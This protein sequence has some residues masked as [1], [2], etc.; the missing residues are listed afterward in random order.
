LVVVDSQQRF[1]TE[2]GQ[3]YVLRR[4]CCGHN[5]GGGGDSSG[6]GGN[7]RDHH[8]VPLVLVPL[9]LRV[10]PVADQRAHL[11]ESLT[12]RFARERF[13]LHVHVPATDGSETLLINSTRTSRR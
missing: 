1:D 8:L 11:T 4:V 12:A 2:I 6:G 7:L 10:L 9:A 5:D 3:V 13:V